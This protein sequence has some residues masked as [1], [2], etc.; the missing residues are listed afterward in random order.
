MPLLTI[1]PTPDNH[2]FYYDSVIERHFTLLYSCIKVH[3]NV[4]LEWLYPYC[5][6]HVCLRRHAVF[7]S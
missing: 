1:G 3:S 2:S 5:L 7:I 6:I 4:S